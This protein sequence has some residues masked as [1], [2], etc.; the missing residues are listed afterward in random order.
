[1]KK[2]FSLGLILAVVLSFSFTDINKSIAQPGKWVVLG[3]RVVNFSVDHDEIP[4]TVAK[5]TFKRIKFKV[6]GAP[7]HVHNFKVIYGNGTSENFVINRLFKAGHESRVIDLKGH[8]R[9]I[10]KININYKTVR[11]GKGKAK[12]IVFGKH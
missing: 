1:M 4:V 10:H 12:V 5:G 8:N 3:K 2:I 9:V 6:V 11:V 7:I